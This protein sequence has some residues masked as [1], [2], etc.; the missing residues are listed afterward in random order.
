MEKMI[1]KFLEGLADFSVK[2]VVSILIVIIGFKVIQYIVGFIK[3]GRG[4]NKLEKSSQTF[5][6][7]IIT[8]V[9][10]AL[11]VISAVTNIGVPMTSIIAVIGSAGLALGLALQGGLS[12]IAG[13]VMIMLFKPFKVGDFIETNSENGTVKEINIFHTVLN[14]VDDRI[15]VIPNG[16]LSNSVVVNYSSMKT[17]KLD[18][19]FSVGYNSDIDKVKK[20]LNE[21][22]EK[23]EKILKDEPIRIA[24]KSHKDSS[25]GIVFRAWTLNSDYWDVYFRVMEN[26]K[27]AFDKNG[28]EIPYP[29]M[30]VHMKK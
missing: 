3:K 7:S 27:K 20:V 4:F 8:V 26:V 22:I 5:I 21:V 14:T 15:V 17:R 10:K 12:N 9:L 1:E 28:I 30:D 2:L 13:G 29:Q 11:V 25:I 16:G 24:V 18:L 19:K 23:E 6:A